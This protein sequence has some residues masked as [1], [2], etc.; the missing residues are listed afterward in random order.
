VAGQ[1]ATCPATCSLP[2]QLKKLRYSRWI[3]THRRKAND[4]PFHRLNSHGLLL[5][6]RDR[7]LPSMLCVSNILRRDK[8][9]RKMAFIHYD[10]V[11]LVTNTFS[12]PH[13]AQK[14]AGSVPKYWEM[15]IFFCEAQTQQSI[16]FCIIFIRVCE[17]W[18]PLGPWLP[19]D[20]S[21]SNS[22]IIFLQ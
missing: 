8:T 15:S 20:C 14:H 4:F 16:V 17:L 19:L 18:P 1:D 6:G 7:G 22:A 11:I 13:S 3:Q 5:N 2:R 9:S 12:E 10:E 21:R